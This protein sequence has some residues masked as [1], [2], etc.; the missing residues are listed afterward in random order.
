MSTAFGP[1]VRLVTVLTDRELKT[2]Q[3]VKGGLCGDCDICVSMCPAQ[4]ANGKAW[5]ADM[6]R[7][8]FYDAFKCRT[9]AKELALRRIGKDEAICGICVA[10]C[11]IG[12]PRDKS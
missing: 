6:H 7:E 1:R 4:A 8:D 5:S 3:P 11:P 12:N 9:K 10:V 2:G